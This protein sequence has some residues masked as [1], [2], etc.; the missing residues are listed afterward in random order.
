MVTTEQFAGDDEHHIEVVVRRLRATI[1]KVVPDEVIEERVRASFA[2]WRAAP[3]RD[4]IPLL[5]ERRARET[6]SGRA[7]G[8]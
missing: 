3:I 2:E 4:F 5:A 1:D 7:T 6:L 8:G